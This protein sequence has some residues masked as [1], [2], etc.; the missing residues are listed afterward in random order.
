MIL[1]LVD[2]MH[3]ADDARVVPKPPLREGW[4]QGPRA[5]DGN[6]API[7]EYTDPTLGPKAKTV[8]EA[9]FEAQFVADAS[10]DAVCGQVTDDYIWYG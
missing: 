10:E 4:V 5:M 3:Q 8:V 6:P 2:L 7:S 1:D 9:L